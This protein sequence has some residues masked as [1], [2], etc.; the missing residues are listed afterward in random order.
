M[1]GVILEGLILEGFGY[2]SGISQT[3]RQ[4]TGFLLFFVLQIIAFI[5][6]FDNTRFRTTYFKFYDDIF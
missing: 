1:V 2:P 4:L 6:Y 3:L 5:N